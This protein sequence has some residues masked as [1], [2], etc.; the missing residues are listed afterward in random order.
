MV[1][2][3]V[4]WIYVFIILNFDECSDNKFNLRLEISCDLKC[5]FKLVLVRF[6][7]VLLR[8]MHLKGK[9]RIHD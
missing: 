4:L 6:T 9:K 5:A 2:M 1:H 7:T 3:K 8:Y